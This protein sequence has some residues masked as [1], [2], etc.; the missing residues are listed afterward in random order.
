[1]VIKIKPE[2]KGLLHKKMGIKKDAPISSAALAKKKKG[3][4]GKLKK[5]IVFA[6]NARKWN[7]GK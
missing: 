1:M 4:T 3:A 7:K 2:N 5:E 6:E